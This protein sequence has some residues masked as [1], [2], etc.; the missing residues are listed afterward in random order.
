[1][2]TVIILSATLS[3]DDVTYKIDDEPNTVKLL[4]TINEPDMVSSPTTLN[5][6]PSNVKLLSTV[7][8][9]DEPLSVN[10]TLS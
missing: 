10:I 2:L 3:W 8:F 6:E 4:V 7:A 9:G 1:M 5:N